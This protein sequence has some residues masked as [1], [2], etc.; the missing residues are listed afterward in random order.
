MQHQR[1]PFDT[2]YVYVELTYHKES[3]YD[4]IAGLYK[5][6][7]ERKGHTFVLI[8]GLKGATNIVNLKFFNIMTIEE[9]KDDHKEFKYFHEKEKDLSLEELKKSHESLVKCSMMLDQSTNIVD[10]SKYIDV[11]TAYLE[12]ETITKPSVNGNV[13]A[14]GVGSTNNPINRYSNATHSSY[15]GGTTSTY[16][17]SYEKKDPEPTLFSRK[18]GDKPNKTALEIMEEKINQIMSGSFTPDLPDTS[19]D[20]EESPS[21]ASKTNTDYDDTADY[22]G[23]GF[24]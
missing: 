5:G 3:K 17:K 2:K 9:L 4:V 6:M 16:S 19:E 12:C 7:M 10:I 1:S 21:Y 11:P 13:G 24:C 18:K 15:T 20:K 22:A 14:Y 23:Y 8:N